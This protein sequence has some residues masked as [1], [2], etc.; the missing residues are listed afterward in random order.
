MPIVVANVLYQA[1][2]AANRAL[3]SQVDGFAAAG[4]LAL[5]FE[6]G[7]RVIGAIGSTLD[8]LLFQIAV[9]A[10]KTLGPRAARRQVSRNMAIQLA[11]LLPAVAGCWLILPSFEHLLVPPAFRGP[12]AQYFALMLPAILCFALASYCVG[13]AFQIAHRTMPLI[14]GGLVAAGADG[15]AVLLLPATADASRFAI[16]PSLASVAGLVATVGFLFTLEPMWPDRRDM[17]GV[18][19]AT[20]AMIVAIAPLRG[21]EPGLVALAAQAG[22]GI[23]VYG[24]V[25][26]AFD[27]AGLRSMA[28]RVISSRSPAWS[29]MVEKCFPKAR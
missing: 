1:V 14:V 26:A 11:V 21:L 6:L 18:L 7:I 3:V 10:E 13:P 22:L 27:V 28:F 2:P 20:V 17:I 5:A 24:A 15:L 8:V 25:I 23:L 4:Q 9:L 16:A 19:S 12:F 29:G